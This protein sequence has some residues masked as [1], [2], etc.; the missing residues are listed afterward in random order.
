LDISDHTKLQKEENKFH[1][2]RVRWRRGGRGEEENIATD[3][4]QMDADKFYS[5]S[6]LKFQ[7]C[8]FK[9]EI[10]FIR[11]HLPFIRG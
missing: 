7:I 10:Q 9:F 6:N 5:I 4:R 11:V 2:P 8:N 3:G 1:R